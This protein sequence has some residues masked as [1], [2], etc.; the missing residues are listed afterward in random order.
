SRLLAELSKKFMIDP[1]VA[2]Q[3][4]ARHDMFQALDV[5]TFIKIVFHVGEAI[6]GELTRSC[7]REL[8]PGLVMPSVCKEDAIL[9]KLLWLMNG[10]EKSRRDVVMMLRG[11]E[12]IRWP[13][14]NERANRLGVGDLLA[15]LRREAAA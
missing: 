4:I 10:S 2:R 9:S 15:Q 13:E 5:G 14:L 12:M 7:Q 6:E 8:I 1:D 3:A 11:P